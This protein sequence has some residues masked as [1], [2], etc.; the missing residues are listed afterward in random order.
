[1]FYL[2]H[3]TRAKEALCF[4]IPYSTKVYPRSPRATPQHCRDDRSRQG[5][6]L[7]VGHECFWTGKT[8]FHLHSQNILPT[9]FR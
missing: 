9:A 6:G 3:T 7:Q 5:A 8:F 4:G 1:M 2:R